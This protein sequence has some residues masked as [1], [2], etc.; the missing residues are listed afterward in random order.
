MK[1]NNMKHENVKQ[2]EEDV[3]GAILNAFI[4]VAPW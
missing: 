1:E 4:V 2:K 3:P